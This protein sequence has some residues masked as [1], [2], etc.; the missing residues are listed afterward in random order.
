MGYGYIGKILRVD[1]TSRQIK[2]EPLKED[3][4]R[5]YIGGTGLA[6]RYLYEEIDASTKPEDRQNPLIFMTGPLGATPSIT[7]GRHQIVSLSPLTGIYG[8]SDCGG[9][10]GDQLKKAGFDGIVV[11]GKSS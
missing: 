4:A 3:W 6:T 11:T 8:E 7:S 1:L 9:S 10:W 5:K 2:P